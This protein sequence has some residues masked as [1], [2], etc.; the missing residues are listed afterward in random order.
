[1]NKSQDTYKIY[2]HQQVSGNMKL[3][4]GEMIFWKSSYIIY[5]TSKKR[6]CLNVQINAMYYAW[7]K[8]FGHTARKNHRFRD[9]Y[10]RDPNTSKHKGRGAP[11]DPKSLPPEAWG[12]CHRETENAGTLVV[13]GALDCCARDHTCQGNKTK[14]KRSF[15]DNPQTWQCRW[16]KQ[17]ENRTHAHVYRVIIVI[18]RVRIYMFL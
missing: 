3:P 15:T 9:N 2:E 8:L 6:C 11:L 17:N 16:R 7:N 5:Y 4:I 10:S 13:V 14:C 1:M 18:T 12:G